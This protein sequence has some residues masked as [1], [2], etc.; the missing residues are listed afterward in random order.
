MKAL[1][2]A[3]LGGDAVSY[4]ALL[5]ELGRYLRRYFVRRLGPGRVDDA[6]D[7]VQETLIAVHDR[8]GTYDIERPFTVWLHAVA[9][10]KLIDY[11]RHHK[12]RAA[13]PI[14][15]VDGLFAADAAE[16]AMARLDVDRLLESIPPRSRA[17]IRSVKLNGDTIAETAAV[18]GMSESAVKV[19][20]HRGVKALAMRMRGQVARRDE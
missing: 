10:Y 14:D 18:T 16:A 13:V 2:I 1:M 9:R 19:G 17:L 5:E 7:L 8:R 20:I 11:F 6:E 3:G 12:V 4:R 15:D